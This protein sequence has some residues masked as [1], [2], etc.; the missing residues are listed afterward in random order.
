MF[1]D[2]ITTGILKNKYFKIYF[3]SIWAAVSMRQEPMRGFPGIFRFISH[4]HQCMNILFAQKKLAQSNI[5]Q[6]LRIRKSFK[7][8]VQLKTDYGGIDHHK[9][10]CRCTFNM[11]FTC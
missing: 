4:Q 2:K 10:S 5:A 7:K 3:F 6:Y 1:I 9:I 11:Y 8:S